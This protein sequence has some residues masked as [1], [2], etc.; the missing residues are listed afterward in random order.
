MSDSEG[1]PRVHDVLYLYARGVQLGDIE[2]VVGC[3]TG[4]AKLEYEGSPEIAGVTAI[5]DFFAQ[6]LSAARM[7]FA[8]RTLERRVSTPVVTNVLFD[9][10]GDEARGT[11]MCLAVHAGIEDGNEVVL[12]RGT[13]N[14]DE[15]VVTSGEWRIRRRTHL[16]HW[17]TILPGI[18]PTSHSR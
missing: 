15:L 9:V 6:N 3:F 8:G 13:E 18:S 4:D 14:R 11:S 17:I 12:M 2:M 7:E 10:S 16:L 1:H 5:R